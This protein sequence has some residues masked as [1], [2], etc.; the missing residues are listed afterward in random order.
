MSYKLHETPKN[1]PEKPVQ[2]TSLVPVLPGDPNIGTHFSQPIQTPAQDHTFA[3]N[4]RIHYPDYF[5]QV[6]EIFQRYDHDSSFLHS[7]IVL[8]DADV[9]RHQIEVL[10]ALPHFWQLKFVASRATHFYLD[11]GV[12]DVVADPLPFA[13]DM[14]AAV[15]D[16]IRHSYLAI[17]T[18]N[19]GFTMRYDPMNDLLPSITGPTVNI[20][21]ANALFGKNCH[22]E[23]G[24]G[25]TGR[26]WAVAMLCY[27]AGMRFGR[28][29]LFGGR[30]GLKHCEVHTTV[31]ERL[32]KVA[33]RKVYYGDEK[34]YPHTL[35][36]TSVLHP[37]PW[38]RDEIH[39]F[40]ENVPLG[41]TKQKA[42]YGYLK[43]CEGAWVNVDAI[44]A[45]ANKNFLC[46]HIQARTIREDVT[47]TLNNCHMK[48]ED[49]RDPNPEAA[50]HYY[51]DE[52]EDPLAEEISLHA[53]YVNEKTFSCF[54]AAMTLSPKFLH[55]IYACFLGQMESRL[56]MLSLSNPGLALSG[57]LAN[58]GSLAVTGSSSGPIITMLT[59]R[60]T[61]FPLEAFI[62]LLTLEFFAEWT[63]LTPVVFRYTNSDPFSFHYDLLALVVMF[64]ISPVLFSR[65]RHV[66]ARIIFDF[67]MNYFRTMDTYISSL[68]VGITDDR[69]TVSTYPHV[70]RSACT[71]KSFSLLSVNSVGGRGGSKQLIQ[72]IIELLNRDL[73]ATFTIPGEGYQIR[74]RS[75]SVPVAPYMPHQNSNE[76]LPLSSALDRVSELTREY[77]RKD[78]KLTPSSG[79]LACL[80]SLTEQLTHFT[81]PFAELMH[82]VVAPI[83]VGVGRQPCTPFSSTIQCDD[84]RAFPGLVEDAEKINAH[85][86]FSAPRLEP[87]ITPLE[88]RTEKILPTLSQSFTLMMTLE[89][90]GVTHQRGSTYFKPLDLAM[91]NDKV[92]NN[93]DLERRFYWMCGRHEEALKKLESFRLAT[94]ITKGTW[95]RRYQIFRD[96]MARGLD[97]VGLRQSSFEALLQM[98]GDDTSEYEST[99]VKN[100]TSLSAG[101]MDVR[102]Y[103]PCLCRVVRMVVLGQ[104]EPLYHGVVREYVKKNAKLLLDVLFDDKVGMIMYRVG[105]TFSMIPRS[106]LTFSSTHGTSRVKVQFNLVE[107][108]FVDPV[109]GNRSIYY[110]GKIGLA[111]ADMSSFKIES[112]MDFMDAI[113]RVSP[114]GRDALIYVYDLNSYTD[115]MLRFMRELVLERMAVIFLPKHRFVLSH[116]VLDGGDVETTLAGRDA[117]AFSRLGHS[118][119]WRLN[120]LFVVDTSST[121][122]AVLPGSI[123]KPLLPIQPSHFRYVTTCVN[124]QDR[125][126]LGE[127][128]NLSRF[129]QSYSSVRGEFG[130]VGMPAMDDRLYQ[131]YPQLLRTHMPIYHVDPTILA[132]RLRKHASTTQQNE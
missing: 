102:L 56:Q 107:S 30:D 36:I 83:M 5:R 54:L 115:G 125:R 93:L 15:P 84:W 55:T 7:G 131:K 11:Y 47:V 13:P 95:M 126:V 91:W 49:Y 87:L 16:T 114:G 6:Q 92:W 76:V 58:G 112:P 109:T 120:P 85:N 64:S 25:L 65:N 19:L 39:E 42:N 94:M 77:A 52:I 129:F 81:R 24:E 27:L 33:G 90:P 51:V 119:T 41:S 118:G 121:V 116:I 97:T 26:I 67:L 111:G 99:W 35:E 108:S 104:P 61:P 72:D 43:F 98:M 53:T 96:L 106:E 38:F 123:K 89:G 66:K 14:R 20:E 50:Y 79:P 59:K 37:I 103:Y 128:L 80:G 124:S 31:V 86:F 62:Q 44:T 82:Y 57:L 23:L 100:Q 18:K 127:R 48:E 63:D 75:F 28:F 32:Q 71:V 70:P 132:Y 8:T 60:L 46:D 17:E 117:A 74:E 29:V 40:M 21:S 22:G 101:P 113:R 4:I 10:T 1:D 45:Q 12:P 88:L 130:S 73:T 68:G 122:G 105:A 3:E 2:S 78:R 9:N 34:E 69:K 110:T